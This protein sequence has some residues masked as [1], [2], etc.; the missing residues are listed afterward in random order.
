MDTN[1]NGKMST[2]ISQLINHSET[3][4]LE[5]IIVIPESPKYLNEINYNQNIHTDSIK[6]IQDNHPRNNQIFRPEY[7]MMPPSNLLT[8]NLVPPKNYN[9]SENIDFEDKQKVKKDTFFDKIK[10]LIIITLLFVLIANKKVYIIIKKF[11]PF[12]NTFNS[13]LPRIFLRG[14][15]LGILYLGID[16]F[17]SI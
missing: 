17:L 15:I 3:E 8:E 14:F 4:S 13:S 10:S 5:K 11:F 7:G 1:N 9:D 16:K 6:T 2:P 12:F